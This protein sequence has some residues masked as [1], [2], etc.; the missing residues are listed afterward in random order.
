MNR[1]P[2]PVSTCRHCARLTKER[3]DAHA[4]LA[5]LVLSLNKAL[6]VHVDKLRTL[7]AG[8]QLTIDKNADEWTVT[9]HHVR[10]EGERGR[11]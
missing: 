2:R 1:R 9:A 10:P 7:V 11:Q 5:A 6:V 4:I 3:D 8:T